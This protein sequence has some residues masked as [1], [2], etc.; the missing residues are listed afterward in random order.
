M[1]IISLLLTLLLV[2]S[3]ADFIE[4]EFENYYDNDFIFNVNDDSSGWKSM[5]TG[6]STD[7]QPDKA[8][9]GPKRPQGMNPELEAFLNATRYPDPPAGGWEN[10]DPQE[11]LQIYAQRLYLDF[12]NGRNITVD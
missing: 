4:E 3:E 9:T 1:K 5:K 6:N 11:N 10:G 2:F 12:L 7:I 8:P